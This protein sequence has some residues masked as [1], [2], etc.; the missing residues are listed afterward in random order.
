MSN[1]NAV[2]QQLWGLDMASPCKVGDAVT[3][4]ADGAVLGTVTSYVDTPSGARVGGCLL[5][6]AVQ[7]APAPGCCVHPHVLA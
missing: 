3:A 7:R 5:G 2:K 6:P 1:L 4:A